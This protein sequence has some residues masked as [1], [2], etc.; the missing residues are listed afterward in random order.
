MTTPVVHSYTDLMQALRSGNRTAMRIG[1]VSRPVFSTYGMIIKFEQTKIQVFEYPSD[2]IRA[3]ETKKFISNN[4]PIY[5]IAGFR[6]DQVHIWSA[7]RLIVLYTGTD[8]ETTRLLTQL[9]GAPYA[10]LQMKVE[11]APSAR[12]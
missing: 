10:G 5:D 9:L 3:A 6:A 11:T 1:F 8:R 4:V 12:S 7:G 2:E